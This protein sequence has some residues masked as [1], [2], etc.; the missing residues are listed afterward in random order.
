MKRIHAALKWLGAIREDITELLKNSNDAKAVQEDNN[1]ILRL[2]D[3]R[4]F[5]LEKRFQDVPKEVV[6][7]NKNEL[8]SLG[9][10]NLLSDRRRILEARDAQLAK[11]IRNEKATSAGNVS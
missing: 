6:S 7:V 9:G 2:I 8:H 1:R 5:E 3:D 11:E 4:I 10:R